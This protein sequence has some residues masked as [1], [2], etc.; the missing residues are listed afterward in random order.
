MPIIYALVIALMLPFSSAF[1]QNMYNQVSLRAEASTEVAHDLMLVSLYT[2]QRDVDAAKLAMDVTQTINQAIEQAKAVS[3]VKVAMGNRNSYPVYDEKRTKI[4]AWRERAEIRLESSNFPALAKL[5]SQLLQSLNMDSMNFTVAKSTKEATEEQL[6][7]QA[8]AAFQHRAELATK[9]LNGKRYKLVNLHL[10]T[11]GGYQAPISRN[12]GAVMFSMAADAP[13][14]NIE[15][16]TSY[17]SVS[18]EGSIQVIK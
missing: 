15:A 13:T 4:I 12:Q 9:A 18:A 11:Q 1:A 2:E 5:T 17:I 7:E 14:P 10:G 16:G 6:I 3:Q 8:I